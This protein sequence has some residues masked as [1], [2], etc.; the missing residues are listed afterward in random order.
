MFLCLRSCAGK[1]CLDKPRFGGPGV[2][3]KACI[4]RVCLNADQPPP[5]P[6]LRPAD[7][8]PGGLSSFGLPDALTL[9]QTRGPLLP[10]DSQPLAA[11]NLYSPQPAPEAYPVGAST[12]LEFLLASHG[13]NWY[14]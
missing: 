6:A 9:L 10:L 13:I 12:K 11:A 4:N 14:R 3:K 7:C 5:S 2:K 1:N 8:K